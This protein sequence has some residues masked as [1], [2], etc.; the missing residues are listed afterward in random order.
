M[1]LEV[2]EIEVAI[3]KVQQCC[4]FAVLKPGSGCFFSLSGVGKGR[5]RGVDR[6][7][8]L[9]ISGVKMGLG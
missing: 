6:Y 7:F 2:T 8:V 1:L 3:T 5:P 9:Y 4:L